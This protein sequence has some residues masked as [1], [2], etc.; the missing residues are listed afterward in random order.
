MARQVR[1][2]LAEPV[3]VEAP[4]VRAFDW[5]AN[6][7]IPSGTAAMPHQSPNVRLQSLPSHHQSLTT[8]SKAGASMYDPKRTLLTGA[9]SRTRIVFAPRNLPAAR[10]N[11]SLHRPRHGPGARG[12][13]RPPLARVSV[14]ARRRHPVA[15]HRAAAR[16][17]A[18]KKLALLR[19]RIESRYCE[20]ALRKLSTS[21]DSAHRSC[22]NSWAEWFL[23]PR[24]THRDNCC[25]SAQCPS[26]SQQPHRCGRTNSS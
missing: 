8:P 16:A 23:N 19:T 10:E 20:Q 14:G 15:P 21:A 25:A 11:T 6:Q 2:W 22:V 17:K 12:H 3:W 4:R 7:R 1:P 18:L 26:P 5:G 24:R 9:W 13:Q